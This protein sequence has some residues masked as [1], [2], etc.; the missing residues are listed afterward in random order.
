MNVFS[1]LL[2]TTIIVHCHKVYISRCHLLIYGGMLLS[3]YVV[4]L[5]LM[6]SNNLS[7]PPLVCSRSLRSLNSSFPQEEVLW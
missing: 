5:P 2:T 1:D 3:V 7:L 4:I 6:Y